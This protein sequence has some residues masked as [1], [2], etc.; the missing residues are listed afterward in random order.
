MAWAHQDEVAETWPQ[1]DGLT[2]QNVCDLS[3]LVPTEHCQTVTEYFVNGTEPRVYDNMYQ[4]FQVNRETGRLATLATPPELIESRI[5]II[6]PE[7]AADWVRENGIEQPPAEYDTIR[8]PGTS[9]GDTAILY[10]GPFEF[11]G[12]LVEIQG[13]AK[14]DNFSNYRVAYYEG[15]APT[16]IHV[17]VEGITE[18]REDAPLAVCLVYLSA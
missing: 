2:R 9:T 18:Q 6:Y 4:E 11:I 3:G 1:P 12:D 8:T 13:N 17:I 14:G 16:E 10:P 5:Y 15:L 7:K